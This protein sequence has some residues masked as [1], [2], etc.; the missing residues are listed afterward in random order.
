MGSGHG[1][2]HVVAGGGGRGRL[3]VAFGIALA[4]L[5]LQVV[6]GLVTGS[7]ALLAD[8]AH[9]ATD[10]AGLGFA[11]LAA[12]VAARPPSLTRTY[13]FL[14]AEV[15]AA[16]LNA[17]L[18]AGAALWVV[19]EAVGRLRTPEPV[20]ARGMLVVA[21][22]G[23]LAN[24][25]SLLVLRGA[26]RG[27]GAG[28]LNLRGAYLE[29]LA[30]L[31]GSVAVI[32]AA[33]LVAVTGS[34]LADPVVGV[35]IGCFVL[36][37]AWHL[38]SEAVDVLLEGAPPG[39]D[40]GEVRAHLEAAPGVLAVHDLHAWRISS[41]LPVLSVHVVVDPATLADGHG[42]VVLDH[43]TACLSE[44]FDVRHCTFQ[45]EAPGHA[46]HEGTVHA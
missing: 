11:L 1:H 2:A 40:L 27:A 20:A 42:G 31:L 13:G 43:V 22:L 26:L 18:L 32:V 46:D 25:V 37:R 36:P 44:D 28:N 9:V 30:D 35:L 4:V 38:L 17:L 33:L 16:A 15:L 3:A 34:P 19:V 45:L 8:A 29:V 41:G 12:V 10:A 39:V 24:L 6:G 14:R 23:L 21:A 7:L 5:V